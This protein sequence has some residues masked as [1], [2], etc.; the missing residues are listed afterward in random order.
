MLR[1]GLPS[2]KL[3][4]QATI[5]FA[6]KAHAA[7]EQCLQ[8]NGSLRETLARSR[9]EFESFR[10]RAHKEKDQVREQA[11]E[12]FAAALLPALDNLGRALE[13]TNF[14]SDVGAVREGV[15]M[16]NTQLVRTLEAEGLVRVDPLGQHFDPNLHEAVSVE[17]RNDVPEGQVIEVMLPGYKFHDRVIRAA[18]V[19]VSAAKQP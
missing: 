3:V 6:S 5:L 10:R 1:A 18:M 8:E 4:A 11:A 15:E 2:E 13:S 16:I 12:A 7:L 17:A 19:K 9:S 14:A